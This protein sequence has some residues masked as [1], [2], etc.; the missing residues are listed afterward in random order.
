M[1]KT[2][3]LRTIGLGLLFAN[4]SM[5]QS[6]K[7]LNVRG[8]P[9]TGGFTEGGNDNNLSSFNNFTS[10]SYNTSW[11]EFGNLLKDKGFVLEE[12]RE[13]SNIANCQVDVTTPCSTPVDFAKMDLS[14]Y[15]IIIMGS[16]NS[17]YSKEAVD[18]FMTYIY[19]GGG[20]LFISDGN[21]GR[22]YRDA[23]LSDQAFA[24]RFGLQMNQDGGFYGLARSRGDFLIPDHPILKGVN[25]FNGEGVTPI[26][27]AQEMPGMS[28]KIVVRDVGWVDLNLTKDGQQLTN[29]NQGRGPNRDANDKD[30]ALIVVE[31]GKGRVAFHYDRN[32][33]FNKGGAGTDLT[34]FD[35]KTYGLNLIDWLKR[36]STSTTPPQLKFTQ[37]F[38]GKNYDGWDLQIRSSDTSLISKTFGVKQDSGWMHVMKDLPNEFELNKGTNPTH[39]LI[40]SKNKYSKY[41]LRWE[42]MWGQKIMNNFNEWPWDAGLFFHIN[43]PGLWNDGYEFQIHYKNA[44]NTNHTGDLMMTGKKGKWYSKNGRSVLPQDGGV[45]S[46]PDSW[47]M[48]A[49]A[50]NVPFEGL[51]GKWNKCELVAMGGEYILFKLN[52]K[53]VNYATQLDASAG[54]FGLQ[55]ETAEIFY[56]NIEIAEVTNT[57]PLATALSSD[58]GIVSTRSSYTPKIEVSANLK[59][60]VFYGNSSV[61]LSNPNEFLVAVDIFS[62]LGKKMETVQLNAGSRFEKSL[63]KGIYMLKVSHAK[64]SSS[65]KVIVF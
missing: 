2:A 46:T 27:V 62:P 41:I 51:N 34:N 39:G 20:A 9:N 26:S 14:Q 56:R 15:S 7:I 3:C 45:E 44:N 19:N 8:G 21:F 36:Q 29:A 48:L 5:A 65:Q 13:G 55:S 61:T 11:G 4:L 30:G 60:S 24:S 28:V 42:Y 32:T 16:N 37:L 50:A 59:I 38:N 22:N 12:I 53:V 23:S 17:R 18:A 63:P 35:N 6:P 25:E 64:Q 40:K 54:N 52:G 33:F 1:I 49:G 31:Y 58:F 10:G 43:S 57:I 47:N